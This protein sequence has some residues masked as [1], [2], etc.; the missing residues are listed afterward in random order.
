[1][2]SNHPSL[3]PPPQPTKTFFDPFH[4]SATGH[5]THA[6]RLAGSTSWRDSRRHKLS[7]QFADASGSGGKKHLA[8]LVGAGSDN[9]R[10]DGRKENG[11]WEPGAPGLRETGWQ[12]IR[13]LMGGPRKRKCHE[14]EPYSKMKELS[15]K[16]ANLEPMEQ[17]MEIRDEP[18]RSNDEAISTALKSKSSSNSPTL[19]EVPPDHQRE[20]QI[21]KSL[22][23][24]ING[25][26]APLVSD[27]RLKQLW[28]Q[29]GGTVSIGLGRKTVTHVVL[30]NA[31][32]GGGGLAS[33]KIQ[34]EI[35]TIR[36][37]GVKFV[38]AKWVL[39]CIERG[40]KL[41]EANYRV[42]EKIGGARQKSVRGMLETNT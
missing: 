26:T 40:K 20:P 3:P 19:L 15:A 30:G 2:P 35:S 16:R 24:Y 14:L 4:S 11:D 41:S 10:K 32:G 12:D 21:F 23:L 22:N 39:D 6:S 34:K 31:D 8:D 18:N 37:K 36:G 28:V 17:S 13:G 42:A 5:Q 38:S 33:S 25:S 7:H 29:H 27:H 1:M 9:F